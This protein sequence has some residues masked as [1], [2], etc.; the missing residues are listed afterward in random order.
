MQPAH[1]FGYEQIAQEIVRGVID[2]IGDQPGL[3]LERKNVV[4]QT[5]ACSVMAFNPR[6]PVETMMAGQCVVYDHMLRHG[7]RDLLSGQGEQITIQARPGILACGKTFLATVTLLLRM[8]RREVAQLA[9]SRP[10]PAQDVEREQADETAEIAA[11]DAAP[12]IDVPEAVVEPRAKFTPEVVAGREAV[13]SQEQRLATA[14]TIEEIED[15]VFEGIDPGVKQ[16]ILSSASL[17]A[18]GMR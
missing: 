8:Q 15:I 9:F 14:A 12:A 17:I 5:I 16:E 2:T 11:H 6:D 18:A 1:T 10:I 13:L 3:S 4:R 7:A